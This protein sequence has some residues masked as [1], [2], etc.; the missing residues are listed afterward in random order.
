MR[1][2]NESGCPGIIAERLPELANA[3]H[4]HAIADHSFGPDCLKQ[5]SLGHQLVH[6]LN[7]AAQH[8]KRFGAQEDGLGSVPQT[9]IGK[10]QADRRSERQ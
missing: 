5:G 6:V 8:G 2:C 7:Q 4:Q 3:D 9:F 10:V 1:R